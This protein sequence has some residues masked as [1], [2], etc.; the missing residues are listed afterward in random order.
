MEHQD[1]AKNT[2]TT[3][4]TDEPCTDI[5]PASAFSRSGSDDDNGEDPP[6]SF[7][8][9]GEHLTPQQCD[10]DDNLNCFQIASEGI[11]P[12]QDDVS[13]PEEDE[14][15]PVTWF[16]TKPNVHD[17]GIYTQPYLL[18]YNGW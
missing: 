1:E 2:L 10:K 13:E 7:S 8:I 4:E 11:K 3:L 12:T 17:Q 14:Q 15:P 16:V 18:Q 5:R 6:F 9:H